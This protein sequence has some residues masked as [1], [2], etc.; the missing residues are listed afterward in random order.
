M[1]NE[2][3]HYVDVIPFEKHIGSNVHLRETKKTVHK[4]DKEMRGEKLLENPYPR[5]SK[6]SVNDFYENR[7]GQAKRLVSHIF[8]PVLLVFECILYIYTN[9]V[10][11]VMGDFLNWFCRRSD[12][13]TIQKYLLTDEMHFAR[14]K[15]IDEAHTYSKNQKSWRWKKKI[16]CQDKQ[17]LGLNIHS[18]EYNGAQRHQK[19]SVTTARIMTPSTKC[20]SHWV[21]F[22]SSH[23]TSS[24]G[25]FT[26]FEK[27][28]SFIVFFAQWHSN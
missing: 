11:C 17:K 18:H 23:H 25:Q 7:C 27:L 4:R 12:L 1:W 3:I 6:I 8:W 5:V 10:W 15:D 21:I 24:R 13:V 14:C 9:G 19:K 26:Q 20:D 2:Q 16:I 28:H 22:R